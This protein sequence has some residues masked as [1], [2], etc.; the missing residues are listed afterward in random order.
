MGWCRD[1]QPLWAGVVITSHYGRV[2]W[3]PSTMGGCRDH[4][5]LWAVSW[6]P[7]TT[8]GCRDHQ[9]LWACHRGVAMG[10]SIW[11]TTI[12]VHF[13]DRLQCTCSCGRYLLYIYLYVCGWC[14]LRE[15]Y[16]SR[17]VHC[18]EFTARSPPH[19][20]CCV[21]CTGVCCVWCTGAVLSI[22]SSVLRVVYWSRD[23]SCMEF[24]AWSVLCVVYWIRAVH[25][26]ECAV[27]GMLEALTKLRSRDGGPG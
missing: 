26:V 1:H 20:V 27:R 15:V 22:A 12:G 2:S 4:Q 19:G 21:W 6:S 13:A 17:A 8:G 18:K 9:P 5:P 23:V 24:T 25:R 11:Y 10:V 16:W 3:S 7:A 14:A